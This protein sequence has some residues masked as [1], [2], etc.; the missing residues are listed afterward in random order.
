MSGESDTES[1]NGA[2][3]GEMVVVDDPET[4]PPGPFVVGPVVDGRMMGWRVAGGV[5]MSRICDADGPLVLA[6]QQIISGRE[7]HNPVLVSRW[8]LLTLLRMAEGQEAVARDGVWGG[9]VEEET[10]GRPSK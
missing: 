9:C 4:V 10:S 3:E 7:A 6:M 2:F 1:V 8:K 5:R